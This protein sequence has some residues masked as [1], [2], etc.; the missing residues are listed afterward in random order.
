M[1]KIWAIAERIILCLLAFIFLKQYQQLVTTTNIFGDQTLTNSTGVEIKQ[2]SSRN[3]SL[4]SP[5]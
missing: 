4:N 5:P 3:L 2:I 1:P